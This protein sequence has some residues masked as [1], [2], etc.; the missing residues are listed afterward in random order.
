MQADIKSLKEKLKILNGNMGTIEKGTSMIEAQ[1]PMIDDAKNMMETK[2][3][4]LIGQVDQVSKLTDGL[5]SKVDGV[6][7][8]ILEKVPAAKEHM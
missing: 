4:G 2:V 5:K 3:G 8:T 1:L 6:E 7:K